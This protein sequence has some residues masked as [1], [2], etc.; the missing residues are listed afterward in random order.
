MYLNNPIWTNILWKKKGSCPSL[1]SE[2]VV[3]LYKVHFRIDHPR[4]AML[5]FSPLPCIS[6]K[7]SASGCAKIGSL[8]KSV[9]IPLPQMGMP[10]MDF[11]V[12]RYL[13]PKTAAGTSHTYST[14][15]SY[16]P[17]SLGDRHLLPTK[18]CLPIFFMYSC[19]QNNL[20][21]NA[22]KSFREICVHL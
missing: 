15:G 18:R 14:T 9:L 6:F 5:F 7:S 20:T 1:K 11:L 13:E 8:F 16:F 17:V 4:K 22:V 3:S 10:V 19:V 12:S 2:H 21:P